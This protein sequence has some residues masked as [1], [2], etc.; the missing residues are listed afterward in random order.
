M[1]RLLKAVRGV[2]FPLG[3]AAGVCISAQE[4]ARAVKYLNPYY[5]ESSHDW[6]N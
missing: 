4:A 5:I 6:L 2:A 3:S 1:H